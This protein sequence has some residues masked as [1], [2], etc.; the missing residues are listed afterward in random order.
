M[1]SSL[2]FEALL[3]V[4]LQVSVLLALAAW[5]ERSTS[6]ARRDRLW[7]IA[8]CLV[9]V[10]FTQAVVL[11]HLRWNTLPNLV[12]PAALPAWQ[13]AWSWTANQCLGIF[14]VGAAIH[15]VITAVAAIRSWRGLRAATVLPELTRELQQ[16]FPESV[17]ARR[18]GAVR[19]AL[20]RTGA[21]CWRWQQPV[22]VL[23]G[24]ALELPEE[25]RRMILR[26]ELAH[27]EAGH[28][29]HVFVQRLVQTLFWFH[30]LVW[31]TSRRAD[32]AREV[33]C[34]APLSE[35][36]AMTYLEALLALSQP[37]RGEPLLPPSALAFARE[38]SLL[39]QRLAALSRRDPAPQFSR[40]SAPALMLAAVLLAALLWPPLN[41]QA[42]ARTR[43]SPW[44]AWSAAALQNLGVPARDFE[45][46]SHRLREHHHP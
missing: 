7:H 40:W 24:R 34:D 21:H 30:P 16:Q 1:T 23:S 25:A 39:Q 35:A 3:A 45:V 5:L 6:P 46:D 11:P 44:P 10:L 22:I 4:T 15:L 26:H 19:R 29:L 36:D 28:P 8:H 17:F 42:S 37:C 12:E 27:L 18:R 41:P 31:W 9:L 13:D 38:G 33:H 2:L 20:G 32:L 14:A 43:W